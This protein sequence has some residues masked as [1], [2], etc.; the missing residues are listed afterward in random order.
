[1]LFNRHVWSDWRL[2]LAIPVAIG[3]RWVMD[4]A[5]FGE[6][7]EKM[8]AE[9]QAQP[10][11]EMDDRFGEYG[12]DDRFDPVPSPTRRPREERLFE[13]HSYKRERDLPALT[14]SGPPLDPLAVALAGGG[15]VFALGAF[16]AFRML[17]EDDTDEE[18][19][20]EPPS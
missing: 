5:L 3:L 19:P 14:S 18:P 13:D 20:A 17:R 9:L 11:L 6:F 1:M 12:F 7:E 15:L 2:L 4:D 10:A 16:F 8:E